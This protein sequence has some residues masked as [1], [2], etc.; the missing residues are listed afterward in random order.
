M[1]GT[2][3]STNVADDW[4]FS[5]GFTLQA[6]VTYAIR[7]N[8]GAYGAAWPEKL[9]AHIGTAQNVGAMTTQV[10][11]N[12]NVINTTWQHGERHFHAQHHAAPT[13]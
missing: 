3:Y 11:D 10:F 12:N 1:P 13:M 5:P 6:G 8:Y 9:A 4:L 2:I 7:F